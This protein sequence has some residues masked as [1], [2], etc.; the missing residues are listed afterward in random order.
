MQA[1][2][3]TKKFSSKIEKIR[4]R[5][6][7]IAQQTANSFYPKKI[8]D[9]IDAAPAGGL[10]STRSIN[11]ADG[12][13]IFDHTVFSPNARNSW[14]KLAVGLLKPV[15]MLANDQYKNDF[16]VSA[17]NAAALKAITEE[18]DAIAAD[19]EETSKV[20]AS[21]LWACSTRKQLEDHYP[22]LVPYLPKIEKQ[23]KAIAVT[24]DVVKKI[25]P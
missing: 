9:W 14:S 22:D 8:K 13:D 12:E 2:T 5:L 6:G 1:A 10:H 21:A 11:L 24:S 15:K 18:L 3:L 23:T 4:K 25:L 19:R 7:T 17:K 16:Q 20:L